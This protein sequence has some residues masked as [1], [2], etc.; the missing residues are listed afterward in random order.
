MYLLVGSVLGG[1]PV[2]GLQSSRTP[3][4][5][6][7]GLSVLLETGLDRSSDKS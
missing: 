3:A 4:D 6:M 7:I 2:A 1:Y 5:G